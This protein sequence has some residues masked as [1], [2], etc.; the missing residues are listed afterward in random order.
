MQT[1]PPDDAAGFAEAHRRLL[2]D[3]SIQFEMGDFTPPKIPEWLKWL[4]EALNSPIAKYAFWAFVALI[5]LAI[6]YGIV[7]QLTGMRLPW[8]A[9]KTKNAAESD[10]R[11][12]EGPAR[13]LLGE[14]DA[15]AS[16]GR[17]DEA[18][19]LLLFRSIDDI[20]SRRPT[21]VRPAL[22]SRDIA[23]AP[24]LPPGPQ[25]AFGAIAM[26]VEKSLFGGRTLEEPDWRACRNAYEEFA[27]AGA[28]S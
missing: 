1:M 22:T 13:A 25:R 14:A 27:F 15:L 7:R 20:E 11:P 26:A 4:F 8:F 6:L 18:A 9:R 2:G 19:R 21:L 5:V 3:S 24:D 28:W 23:L 10:W 12:E 16:Q 17:F